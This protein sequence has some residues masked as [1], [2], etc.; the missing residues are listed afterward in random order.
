MVRSLYPHARILG[1][2][3]S[4][5]KTM[6]GVAAVLT[7][8]DCA[9]GGLGAIPH[10]PVPSTRTDLKLT[11][12]GGGPIFA[13]PHAV[14]PEHKVR[15][16]GEPVAMVVAETREQAIDASEAVYVDYEPLPWVADSVAAAGP[17][18]PSIWEEV[19]DNVCCDTTFGDPAATAT[20]FDAADH[21]LTMTFRDR[22]DYRCAAGA[23][24]GTGCI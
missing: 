20:A 2:D 19:P 3:T 12:P 23:P 9:A 5:A 15:H 10:S 16:V 8:R 21:V 22:A 24:R 18:S 11:A 1:V 6:P 17:D 14:L 13:G 7:G 4:A